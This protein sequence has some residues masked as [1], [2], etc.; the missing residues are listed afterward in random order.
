[1]HIS[2]FRDYISDEDASGNLSLSNSKRSILTTLMIKWDFYVQCYL[3]WG[4]SAFDSVLLFSHQQDIS[5]NE[6][7]LW[8]AAQPSRNKWFIFVWKQS[9]KVWTLA[10]LEKSKTFSKYILSFLDLKTIGTWIPWV[11]VTT[12]ILMPMRRFSFIKS[13]C[14]A[15][16]VV[17]VIWVFSSLCNRI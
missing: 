2:C 1:M 6:N 4:C 15:W 3:C 13:V 9:E 12:Y 10:E 8:W 17:C 5:K 16:R 7:Q 11:S 14:S